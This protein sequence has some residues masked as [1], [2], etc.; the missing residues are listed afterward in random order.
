[1]RLFGHRYID[2]SRLS[3]GYK[4]QRGADIKS[5]FTK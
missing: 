2:R 3:T 5:A 4:R 1:M